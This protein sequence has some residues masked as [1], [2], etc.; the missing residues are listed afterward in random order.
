MIPS[1]GD[2]ARLPTPKPGLCH[3]AAESGGPQRVPDPE[4]EPGARAIR[5]GW[6]LAGDLASL[7][8]STRRPLRPLQR[9][10]LP[11]PPSPGERDQRHIDPLAR[12]VIE[13]LQLGTNSQSANIPLI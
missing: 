7:P 4:S 9:D 13:A 12:P 6:Y 5:D 3:L 1:L 8:L 10:G 2:P 11:L